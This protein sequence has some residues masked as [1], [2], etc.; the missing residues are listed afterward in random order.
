MHINHG[1]NIVELE[2]VSFAYTNVP[3]LKSINLT[4]HEGDYLGVI[5]PNGGGKTTLLKLMLGLLKPTSGTIKIFGSNI[6]DFKNWPKIGYIPQKAVNFDSNFPATVF[7]VAAMGRYGKEGLLHWP[8]K[9]DKQKIKEALQKVGMQDFAERLIGDLSSGQQQRVFI[10]RALASEP[11]IIF[12][13]EPTVGVDIKA[14]EEFYELLKK[15]NRQFHLT[16]ILVSH[17]IDV[18]TNEV[19]ELACINQELVYHGDPEE[20][21]SKDYIKKLYGRGVKFILH[22]H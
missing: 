3:V 12:L 5:G 11:E 14:Q 17:D 21:I 4:I 8:G 19:T 2:S 15:L 10:A 13:D 18:V 22:G 6:N 20:F 9:E 1:E 7:E 16:L